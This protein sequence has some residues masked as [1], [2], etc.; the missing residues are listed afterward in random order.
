MVLEIALIAFAPRGHSPWL[1]AVFLSN[2]INSGTAEASVSGF[3]EALAYDSLTAAGI[4]HE[5]RRVIEWQIRCQAEVFMAA[6]VGRICCLEGGDI[7][8]ERLTVNADN[9]IEKRLLVF[10]PSP[11]TEDP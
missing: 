11:N 8:H 7:L 1:F 6:L 9:T 10:M 3:D 5:R 4:A 2:R